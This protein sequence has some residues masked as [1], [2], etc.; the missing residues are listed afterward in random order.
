MHR[1]KPQVPERSP[2]LPADRLGAKQLALRAPRGVGREPGPDA[3]DR[4]PVHQAAV[5]RD[6][7]GPGTLRHQSKEGSA[8]HAPAGPRGR[9]S[10]A[11]DQP[12]GSWPQG[13][14]VFTAEYGDYEARPGLGERHHL[15][16]AAARLPLPDGLDGPLQPQRAVVA[17]LQHA[18]RRLLPGGALRGVGQSSPQDLQHGSRS[19][20]HG[21][22][23]HELIGKE[24][25]SHLDGWLR[26]SPR[27]RVCRKALAHGQVRGGLSTGLRRWLARREVAGEVLRL[28]PR[29]AAS[30][31]P[32]LPHPVGGLRGG[33]TRQKRSRSNP[34]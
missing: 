25:R 10:E 34:R 29:R 1:P 30:P 27:Q 16:S 11:I 31:S 14:S 24:W 8:A 3:G 19:S 33:L 32:R 21:D 22:G 20:V 18:Y 7:E 13:L 26:P 6:A 5:L 4:P 12:P 23:L 17:A 2:A 9:L 28:L 15:H